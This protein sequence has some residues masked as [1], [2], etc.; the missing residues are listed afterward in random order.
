MLR[1]KKILIGVF[2]TLTFLVIGTIGYMVL[3]Q[4]TLLEALYM[5]VITITTAVIG[6]PRNACRGC[7]PAAPAAGSNTV[8]GRGAAD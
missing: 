8:F 6:G 1:N 2:V 3:E 5:T 4:F 7:I